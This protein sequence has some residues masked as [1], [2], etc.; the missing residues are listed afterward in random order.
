MY[1]FEVINRTTSTFFFFFLEGFYNIYCNLSQY[2]F[3]SVNKINY[4][5][6]MYILTYYEINT[7]LGDP[8]PMDPSSNA[9]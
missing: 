7:L 9:A 8:D 5:K 4:I 6:K 2:T 3:F 1:H